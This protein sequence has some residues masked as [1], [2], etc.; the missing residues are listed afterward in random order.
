M[1]WNKEDRQYNPVEPIRVTLQVY[2]SEGADK[3]P[4]QVIGGDYIEMGWTD[5]SKIQLGNAKSV[6]ILVRMRDIADANN[7]RIQ[8]V[9]LQSYRSLISQG[10]TMNM[11]IVK[12]V[13]R[14]VAARDLTRRALWL[15]LE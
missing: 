7:P 9:A 13:G 12:G 1:L 15:E 10:T 2:P 8:F 14:V 5:R 6:Q 3:L 4:V 11:E